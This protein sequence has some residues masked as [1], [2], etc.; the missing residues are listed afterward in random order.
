MGVQMKNEID[1]KKLAID[2]AFALTDCISYNEYTD[3]YECDHC[4]SNY[5]NGNV[6]HEKTCIAAKAIKFMER[7]EK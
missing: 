5:I 4:F 3:E 6:I 2:F 1:Y 7:L